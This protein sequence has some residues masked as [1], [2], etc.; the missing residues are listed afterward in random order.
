[1]SLEFTL[2]LG[3]PGQYAVAFSLRKTPMKVVASD[4][5]HREN[6]LALTPALIDTLHR[7]ASRQGL[8]RWHQGQEECGLSLEPSRCLTA[9]LGK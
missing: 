2:L 5:T 1:V 6:A 9:L 4:Y 7:S 8:R 3:F